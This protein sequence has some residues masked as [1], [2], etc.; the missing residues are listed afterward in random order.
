M[1]P[2]P[3]RKAGQSTSPRRNSARTSAISSMYGLSC[4]VSKISAALSAS[5]T[6]ANG[7]QLECGTDRAAGIA[8]GGLDPDMVEVRQALQQSAVRDA[9]ERDAAGEAEVTALGVAQSAAREAKHRLLDDRLGRGGNVHVVDRDRRFRIAPLAAEQFLEGGVCR[10]LAVEIAKERGVEAVGA[11]LAQIE[12]SIED[13]IGVARFA[14]GRQPHQ[15]V[16]AGIDLEPAVIGD[17]AVEQAEGMRVMDLSQRRH[18][19]VVAGGDRG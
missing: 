13:Q 17:G 10:R 4:S 16:L 3:S 6:G 8:R 14:I 2:V 11:V 5:T 18:G 1:S 15:L 9:I 12:E 7:R 19:A